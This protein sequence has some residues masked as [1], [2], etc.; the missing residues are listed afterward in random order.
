M[1]SRSV[2]AG[3]LLLDARQPEA[4]LQLREHVV[5]PEPL[6]GQKDQGVEPEVRTSQTMRSAVP[7]LAAM[8]VSV[9]SSPIFLRMA[10]RPLA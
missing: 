3:S 8:T 2:L 4:V 9:A 5:R 1:Q 10:S 6:L 7:S